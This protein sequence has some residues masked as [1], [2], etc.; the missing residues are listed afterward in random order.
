[1]KEVKLSEDGALR[2]ED[3]LNAAENMLNLQELIDVLYE[4]PCYKD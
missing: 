2:G 3:L 4:A 1:M